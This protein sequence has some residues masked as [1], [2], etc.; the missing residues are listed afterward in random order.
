MCHYQKMSLCFA[1]QKQSMQSDLT[2]KRVWAEL[3]FKN[4]EVMTDIEHILLKKR[5]EKI[6][7][8]LERS[9]N[10]PANHRKPLC[11]LLLDAE[12]LRSSA[13]F[14]GG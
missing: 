14:R 12:Q 3:A 4:C 2:R 8:L 7:Y 10:M 6:I 1:L 13:L 11:L 9:L 5:L